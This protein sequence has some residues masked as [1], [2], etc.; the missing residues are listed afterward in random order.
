MSS[1]TDTQAC[2]CT[3]RFGSVRCVTHSSVTPTHLGVV[4]VRVCGWQRLAEEPGGSPEVLQAELE[5]LVSAMKRRGEQLHLLKR[6][7]AVRLA[8]QA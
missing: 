4:C 3:R 7:Y 8:T 2:C 1:T 6:S 5:E